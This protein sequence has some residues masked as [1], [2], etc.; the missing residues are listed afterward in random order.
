MIKSFD[1]LLTNIKHQKNPKTVIIAAAQ[2]ES[3]LEA[4]VMAKKEEI[5]NCF[6]VGDKKTIQKILEDHYPAFKTAFQIEDTGTNLQQACDRA[7]ELVHEKKGELILKGKADTALL[8]KSVLEKEKGLATSELMSDIL[9]YETAERLVLLSDGGIVLYP[10]L[11]E[12]ISIINNAV[13]VAHALGYSLPKVAL[14]AAVE[15]VNP[16]MTCTIDAAIIT[17]M[18]QRQQI[19]NCIIDG[20]LALDNAIDLDSVRKKGIESPVAGLADILIGPNIESVNIFAKALTYYA[21]FR[22]AHVVMGSKV[23]ILIAS[24]ADNA[25]TKMLSIALGIQCT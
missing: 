15:T 9:I 20:P 5:A 19:S 24:R 1:E 21:K 22:V 4:A 3:V 10:G 18:N 13:K 23:P 25:E 6:L 17:K 16:K 8:L 12:K 11:K 14:L 2:S 7:V